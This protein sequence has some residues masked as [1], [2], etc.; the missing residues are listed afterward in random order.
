MKRPSFGRNKLPNFR[1]AFLIPLYLV[2]AGLFAFLI[3]RGNMQLLNPAGYIADAQSKILWGTLIFAA[4]VG[5]T[6]IT[7]FFIVVFRYREGNNKPYDPSGKVSRSVV[8]AGW[9]LQLIVIILI[10][11]MV[12][13]TAHELDP[14]QPISGYKN[15]TLT[16]EVVALQWKWLFIYP[17]QHIATI[18]MLEIPT[19]TQVS[20]MLTADAPMNSFWIPQLSGQIYAMTGMIN[21]L[22]IETDR[23]GTYQ[24]SPAEISGADFAGMMFNVHAVPQAEFNSWATATARQS[25]KSIDYTMFTKMAK[26]SSYQPV[27]TYKLAYDNLFDVV[28]MQYMVPGLQPESALKEGDTI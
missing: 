15:K 14:Y 20:F 24:G 18:N 17:E 2:L 28:V 12:W 23:A 5:I 1:F 6:M 16:V 25:T 22:H 13:A 19:H 11:T 9:W 3:H 10:S 21:Q 27:S 4:V 8:A 26:P 7:A